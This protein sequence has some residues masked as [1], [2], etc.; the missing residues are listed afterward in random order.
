MKLLKNV[1]SFKILVEIFCVISSICGILYIVEKINDHLRIC[2]IMKRGPKDSKLEQ[3]D[4][5]VGAD[6]AEVFE[7]D[8]DPHDE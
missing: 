7:V 2:R 8:F 1:K 6:D 5:S 4:P 3:V